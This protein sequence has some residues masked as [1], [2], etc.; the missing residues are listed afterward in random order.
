MSRQ[1]DGEKK[2]GGAGTVNYSRLRAWYL[3]SLRKRI[4]K[5]IEAGKLSPAALIAADRLAVERLI[6]EAQEPEKRK[7]ERHHRP[8]WLTFNRA[9][10]ICVIVPFA[11]AALVVAAIAS[12][13]FSRE[14]VLWEILVL[15]AITST[16]MAVVLKRAI[17]NPIKDIS[18]SALPLSSPSANGTDVLTLLNESMQELNDSLSEATQRENAIADYALD[19]IC[20]LDA[21]GAFLAVS[22][23]SIYF[24]G[25][26]NHELLGR[27]FQDLVY[28]EDQ[29]RTAKFLAAM[30]DAQ[31][32]VPFENR[33]KG[34]DGG[35]I[36]IMWLTEWSATEGSLFCIGR[37]V[38]TQKRLERMKKEFVS[39]IGHDLRTPIASVGCTLELL[40]QG[41]YGKLTEDGQRVVRSAHEGTTRLINLINDLLDLEKLQVGK[42]PLK[43]ESTPLSCV[44]DGAIESVSA[45]LKAQDVT[46]K[47]DSTDATVKADQ[48]RL[49][50]VVVNLL[51][52]AIKFS[53]RGGTIK[54]TVSC[55]KDQATVSIA[56][57]GPGIPPKYRDVIFE[58]FQQA[59]DEHNDE[60]SGLGLS[61]CQAI[62]TAHD[63]TIGVDSVAGQGSN[64]WFKIPL[65]R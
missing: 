42:L 26:A 19:F 59:Q 65:A 33:I 49:T 6:I 23:S 22:P 5:Q 53:P 34:K 62:V 28:S 46:L 1:L 30:S 27:N 45:Y 61:I 11:A 35:V 39:M 14:M 4:I 48:A 54:L 51:G 50:Q 52:N 31:G 64:F 9:V 12:G 44:I 2:Q 47:S 17:V 8:H 3:A 37:D 38:S 16:L 13:I 43:L 15:G 29:E 25:Y 36:D 24:C 10:F 40:E 41:S 57:Q 56:D 7:I 18:G 58:R 21:N 60:G 63:G 20:A 32:Q 55:S